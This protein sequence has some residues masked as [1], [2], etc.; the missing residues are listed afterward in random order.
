MV[1]IPVVGL[2]I[3]GAGLVTLIG[4]LANFAARFGAVER[5]VMEHAETDKMVAARL[6]RIED[7]LLRER[8]AT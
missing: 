3:G 4:V 6:A 7:V 2:I 1:T 8:G 5:A